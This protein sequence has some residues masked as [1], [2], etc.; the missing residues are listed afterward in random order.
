[1]KNAAPKRKR[2][3][4]YVLIG[5]FALLIGAAIIKGRQSPK[6]EEVNAEAA[7]RRTIREMVSASGKIFPET[8]VKISSDVSGE[9]IELYVKE[10]EIHRLQCALR[11]RLI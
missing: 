10:G 6:G 11:V 7:Q 8:E 5:V 4:L 2:T 3:L 1:M 9:I